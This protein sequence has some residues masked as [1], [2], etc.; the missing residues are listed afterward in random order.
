MLDIIIVKKH[1]TI[2]NKKLPLELTV[3]RMQ[4]LAVF[5]FVLLAVGS[6]LADNYV[7]EFGNYIITL[8]ISLKYETNLGRPVV[9][10]MTDIYADN[11]LRRATTLSTK[12]EHLE[13]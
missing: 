13:F 1:L 8:F 5:S 11:R 7:Y 12:I 3:M 10:D 2:S 4:I 6:S 9:N